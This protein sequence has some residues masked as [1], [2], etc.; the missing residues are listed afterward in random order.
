MC[1]K[2]FFSG[3]TAKSHKLTHPMQEYCGV[4]TSGEAMRDWTKVMKNKFRSKQYFKKHP[5]LGYLPVQ[6]IMEGGGGG[7]ERTASEDLSCPDT[8][9]SASVTTNQS[10]SASV[11]S[12]PKE[13]RN[14]V[15][16][17][18]HNVSGS[19]Q[20]SPSQSTSSTLEMHSCVGIQ[21]Q[22]PA[23]AEQKQP[24][25]PTPATAAE[26]EDEHRLIAQYC[27][28]LNGRKTDVLKSPM[29]ILMGVDAEQQVEME[30]TI[31][32]L[33][34]VNKALQAEYDQ[35]LLTHRDPSVHPAKQSSNNNN[36][37]EDSAAADA[38]RDAELL[39]EAKQLTKHKAQLEVRMRILEDH[40]RQ[41]EA[42]L[43]RLHLLLD[44]SETD[45]GHV[46]TFSG[47]ERVSTPG[48]SAAS[49]HS[50][51]PRREPPSFAAYQQSIRDKATSAVQNGGYLA[52]SE[53]RLLSEEEELDRMMRELQE[54]LPPS[55]GGI[56]NVDNLFHTVGQVSR[57]V[58]TLVTIMTE[59][60][61]I[62]TSVVPAATTAATCQ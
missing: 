45:G 56:N 2:C 4:S 53:Q 48:L 59:E 17:T 9:A 19:G 47:S 44:Q 36:V 13:Q 15:I 37:V 46:I 35:L 8:F 51:L 6:T 33:E 43:Q 54:T 34:A 18:T 38:S 26:I 41:L 23:E 12:T 62:A 20:M 55:E 61:S 52:T 14:V 7:M 1:Q 31:R 21:A 30:A 40:N 11:S 22:R 24:Q 16:A 42:Q 3:Q 39:A 10:A 58:G 25:Q 50:S 60:E 28:N 32:D 27:H 5:R 49:S 29:Q 57:A